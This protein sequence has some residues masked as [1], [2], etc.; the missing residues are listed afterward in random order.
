[1]SQALKCCAILVGILL[2][3]ICNCILKMFTELNLYSV[4]G[5]ACIYAEK[6]IHNLILCVCTH[7]LYAYYNIPSAC[8]YA[9]GSFAVGTSKGLK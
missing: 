7:A 9:H 5:Y 4:S 6:C 3:F 1:M 8:V 2:S